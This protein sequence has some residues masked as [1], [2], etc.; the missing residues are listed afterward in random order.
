[1]ALFSP[2]DKKYYK[3]IL[4]LVVTLSCIVYYLKFKL[5]MEDTKNDLKCKYK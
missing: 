4:K 3:Q 1:M 5:K 2:L